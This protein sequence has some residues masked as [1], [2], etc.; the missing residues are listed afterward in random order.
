MFI[1][2]LLMTFKKCQMWWHMA[3]VPAVRRQRQ[4]DLCE[5]QTSQDY[6]IKFLKRLSL[7]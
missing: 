4:V 7:V 3:L 5:F 2:E 1:S 6:I